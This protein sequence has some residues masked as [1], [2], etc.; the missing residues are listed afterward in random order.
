MPVNS[1]AK[2]LPCRSR[3][4]R[5]ARILFHLGTLVVYPQRLNTPWRLSDLEAQ[6]GQT[7]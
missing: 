6:A 1:A 5:L 4:T 3:V 7:W 2:A